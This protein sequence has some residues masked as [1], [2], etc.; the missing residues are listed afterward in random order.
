MFWKKLTKGLKFPLFLYLLPLFFVFHGFVE[1]FFLVPV[2]PALLLF[3]KYFCATLV[4]H[5]IFYCIFKNNNK[6][7]LF[8]FLLFSTYYFF[9]IFHDLLKKTFP[10]TYITKYSFILPF[11]LLLV[12]FS[13]INIKRKSFPGK[14]IIY[15]NSLFLIFLIIDIFSL[16]QKISS[17]DRQR[18]TN[19]INKKFSVCDTCSKP[20]IYLIITD[21]YAGKKTLAD[22]YQN[23]NS[24]FYSELRKRKFQISEN[25]FSNYNITQ[26]SIASILNLDYLNLDKQNLSNTPMKAFF[27]AI[28]TNILVPFLSFHGYQF[29]N[30]SVFQVSGQPPLAIT[31]FVPVNTRIIE[32]QTLS[33]RLMK[34][35]GHLLIQ[36]GLR[37]DLNGDNEYTVKNNNEKII[38]N[39]K[40]K[41]IK[42]SAAP[43]FVYSHLMM[44][45]FP[46][47][48]DSLGNASP[49]SLIIYNEE[50]IHLDK[51]YV[52]YLKYT[53]GVL[54]NIVD[55]ILQHSEKP[56]VIMILSD[57]G[58]RLYANKISR[59]YQFINLN[60][61][62]FPKEYTIDLPDSL[63]NI[64]YMRA[65]LNILFH[66]NLPINKQD[67]FFIPRVKRD[68]Q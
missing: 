20:D 33:S 6:A 3:A 51:M 60:A 31:P 50:N 47:Y 2:L 63:S 4:L 7:A 46:Y 10:G 30:N 49:T 18:E 52:S 67:T 38:A 15:L 1:Y 41:V 19:N 9:G 54:L 40:K 45:H 27:N 29:I 14:L 24:S 25:S 26:A 16:Q 68:S 64:S 62:Y 43:K 34:D 35:L 53:N 58:F 8:V 12:V 37:G 36:W 22:I 57:H 13:F 61:T 21:E 56:P 28:D 55:Y 39:L 42:K 5:G 65:V 23:D 32:Y 44:P 11:L 66:Q 59:H 17:Y 48:F